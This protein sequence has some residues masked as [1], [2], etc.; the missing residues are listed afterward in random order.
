VLLIHQGGKTPAFTAGNTCAGLYGDI[1]PILPRL[2]PAIT[3]V[4]SGHTHWAYVCRGTP[5][6]AADRL[7]TSAGKYGYF[8]TDLR[9]EFDPAT[10]RLIGQ[11]AHNIVVGNG[12]RGEDAAERRLVD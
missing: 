12:E 11:D 4:I 8:V 7:L 5:Q 6:A 2:D 1:L 3:T 9:L 10:H